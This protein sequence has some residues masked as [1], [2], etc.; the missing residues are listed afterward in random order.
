MNLNYSLNIWEQD[1]NQPR[2]SMP[3]FYNW[4]VIGNYGFFLLKVEKIIKKIS[5]DIDK[6]ISPS[7]YWI[8][9]LLTEAL[10]NSFDS[11]KDNYLQNKNFIWKI[12]IDIIIDLNNKIITI[13]MSDNWAWINA[14]K[15]EDKKSSTK[16]IWW[17]WVWL[18]KSSN[19]PKLELNQNWAK[20]KITDHFNN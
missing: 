9:I 2:Y 13:I 14:T 10:K 11:C 12:C 1:F 15:T 6:I 17:A 18:T 20:F 7:K 8:S 5:E 4:I 16:F 19:P 3:I